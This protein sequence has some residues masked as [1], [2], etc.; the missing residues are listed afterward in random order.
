MRDQP[1]KQQLYVKDIHW[2]ALSR[3]DCLRGLLRYRWLKHSRSEERSADFPES[4]TKEN[5]LQLV[6]SADYSDPRK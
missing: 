4:A 5:C 1:L 2:C 6:H 3:P